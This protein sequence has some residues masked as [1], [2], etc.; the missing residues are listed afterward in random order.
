ML[1]IVP[2]LSL[3]PYPAAHGVLLDD[4]NM[5]IKHTMPYDI[6]RKMVIVPETNF[7]HKEAK[8]MIDTLAHIDPSILQKSGRSSYLHSAVER[9]DYR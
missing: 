6:L 8:T 4:S 5:G 1:A 9:E 2:L 3:S 7:S